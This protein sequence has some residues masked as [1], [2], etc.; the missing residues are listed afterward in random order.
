MKSVSTQVFTIPLQS[1][2]A[3]STQSYFSV[4]NLSDGY[5]WD[6]VSFKATCFT[7]FTD[8]W[9]LTCSYHNACWHKFL[10]AL[11][12]SI[13]DQ[14]SM[15]SSL[16]SLNCFSFP[17]CI[18]WFIFTAS[19]SNPEFSLC[20]QSLLSFICT[21]PCKGRCCIWLIFGLYA[22]CNFLMLWYR[23]AFLLA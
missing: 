9:F 23:V 17:D 22:A 13:Y 2:I 19:S 6:I 8:C 14:Y 5:S 7:Y 4:G 3:F 12:C 15:I 16:L 1:L 20:N 10:Q 21:R 18:S 11:S